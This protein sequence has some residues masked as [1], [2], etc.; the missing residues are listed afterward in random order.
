MKL[1]SLLEYFQACDL[2]DELDPDSEEAIILDQAIQDYEKRVF[3]RPA[4]FVEDEEK[5]K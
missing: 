2:L 3:K 1:H 4:K 5:D